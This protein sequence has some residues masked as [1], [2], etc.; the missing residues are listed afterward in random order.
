MR[1]V[2][3]S[4]RVIHVREYEKFRK[5]A[6]ELKSKSMLYTMQRAPLSNPP[7]ALRFIFTS[8]DKQYI[9]LDFPAGD[10]LRQTK[11]PI[12]FNKYGEAYIDDEDIRNFVL[13][14]LGRKDLAIHSMEVLGY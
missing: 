12:K 9:F 3:K 8:G 14:E 11:I 5:L 4:N 10:K 2:K 6:L 13:E 7:I 1:T